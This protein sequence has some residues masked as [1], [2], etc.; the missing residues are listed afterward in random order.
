MA[1]SADKTIGLILLLIII[2]AVASVLSPYIMMPVVHMSKGLVGLKNLASLRHMNFEFGIPVFPSIV[3]MLSFVIWIVIIFWVYNDAE[4]RGMSG[5]LWALLVFIGNIVGLLI[6]LIVRAGNYPAPP[7]QRAAAMPSSCPS[8]SK[9]VQADF[10][11]C[12]HCGTTL[13]SQC[14]SCGKSTAPEWKVCPYCGHSMG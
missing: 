10:K 4:R 9:P 7:V 1:A 12:P 3:G 5:I 8:C 11:L 14:P 13:R 6:Y 2:I